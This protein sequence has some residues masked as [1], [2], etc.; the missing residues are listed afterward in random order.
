MIQL[1]TDDTICLLLQGTLNCSGRKN[2]F[3]LRSISSDASTRL[4]ILKSASDRLSLQQGRKKLA[5]R[6]LS[7]NVPCT[8]LCFLT[9]L[10]NGLQIEF[11]D[12][13]DYHFERKVS[14]AV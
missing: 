5:V 3:T 8:T 1:G 14:K 12:S 2:A 6:L 13:S 11:E 9:G 7:R 10:T 4:R